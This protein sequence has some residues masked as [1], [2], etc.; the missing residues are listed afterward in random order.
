MENCEQSKLESGLKDSTLNSNYELLVD[1][2]ENLSS[3]KKEYVSFLL[4]LLAIR[5]K[6]NH[7]ISKNIFRL[8]DKC[9]EATSKTIN[10]EKTYKELLVQIYRKSQ[11]EVQDH[12]LDP[13]S[14]SEIERLLVGLGIDQRL[15][16]AASR[17]E[18]TEHL[19]EL[20]PE[21]KAYFVSDEQRTD[22]NK[23]ETSAGDYIKRTFLDDNKEE[24]PD[25]ILNELFS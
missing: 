6:D 4:L 25:E 21:L 18:R 11:I 3:A 8:E 5:E 23:T 19:K 14:C 1:F 12:L 24:I 2:L 10:Q 22:R 15:P 17:K 9:E 7:F 13:Q 16:A 20:L